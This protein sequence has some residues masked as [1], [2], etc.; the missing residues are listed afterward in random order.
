[1]RLIRL[2]SVGRSLMNVKSE[3]N[4]YIA[5]RQN[6]I[7]NLQA[8]TQIVRSDPNSNLSVEPT[9]ASPA[10]GAQR[11]DVKETAV[12]VACDTEFTGQSVVPII[13]T[14]VRSA[15]H[16]ACGLAGASYVA[17]LWSKLLHPFSSR[18]VAAENGRAPRGGARLDTVRVVRNDLTEVDLELV[19]GPI[20]S[21][22]D[23][24]GRKPDFNI[25]STGRVGNLSR[26]AAQLFEAGRLRH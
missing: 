17:K 7:P 22:R 19:G 10:L 25:G 12:S 15:R 3:P 20:N 16:D 13:P 8:V 4:R 6:L 26:L 2:L 5:H 14:V 1:M 18:P 9:F 23:R 24:A 11:A 21:R